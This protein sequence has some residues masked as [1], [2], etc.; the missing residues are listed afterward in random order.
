MELP[1]IKEIDNKSLLEDGAIWHEE[2]ENILADWADKAM[3]FRWLHN[4]SNQKFNK[5]NTIFTIP[6]IVLST[7]T[8]TANFAQDR[9][10]VDYRSMFVMSVGSLNLI[11]GIISTIQQFLKISELNESHR[12]AS[13]AWDKFYRNIK[14]ELAKSP[15]ERIPVT[16]MMKLTKEEFDRLMETCPQ[17]PQKIVLLFKE[18]FKSSQDFAS[19][20]KPEICDELVPTSQYKYVAKEEPPVDTNPFKLILNQQREHKTNKTKVENFI[21]NFKELNN[22]N[23]LEDEII[24]NLEDNN[25]NAKKIQTIILELSTD[26]S[27]EII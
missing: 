16:Q 20:H 3:C 10:P 27:N 8:G 19:I 13:I 15:R 7:L 14:I 4:R 17:I 11:A 12:V 9:V 26:K 2:H 21:T 22:R 5:L 6:V 1:E 23:P 24:E 25:L 18:T